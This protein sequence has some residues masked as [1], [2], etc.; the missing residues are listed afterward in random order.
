ME[1]GGADDAGRIH[2]ALVERAQLI[3]GRSDRNCEKDIRDTLATMSAKQIAELDGEYKRRYG[4]EKDRH[5]ILMD[6]PHLSGKTKQAI[7]T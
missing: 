6:D 5:Q 2:T 3:E 7:F 1:D 4:K